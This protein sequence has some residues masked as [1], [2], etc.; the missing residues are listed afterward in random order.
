MVSETRLDRPADNELKVEAQLR[1]MLIQ[2]ID[3]KG[4]NQTAE[5]L[6]LSLFGT[7]MLLDNKTWPLSLC[8]RIAEALDVNVTVQTHA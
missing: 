7:G 2:V 4:K 3:K 6:G 5:A 8:M 1:A